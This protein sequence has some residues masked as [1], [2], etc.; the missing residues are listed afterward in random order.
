MNLLDLKTLKAT[1]YS[2]SLNATEE[3]VTLQGLYFLNYTFI[4]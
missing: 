1:G 3:G 4:N 2:F